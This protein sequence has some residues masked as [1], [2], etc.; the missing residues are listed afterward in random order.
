MI[1]LKEA[2]KSYYNKNILKD[3]NLSINDNDFILLVGD[4]GSG[5]STLLKLLAHTIYPN[6]KGSINC[7]VFNAYLPEKFSLPKNITVNKYIR[8]LEDYYST[9]LNNIVS[10][11]EIPYIKI[12]ELSK[13]N[14][15]KLGLITIIASNLNTVLLDEP[16][17]GMD[18]ELKK[19]F[20]EILKELKKRNKTIIISTHD[21]K[22]YKNF[23]KRI[24][25]VN[26]GQIYEENIKTI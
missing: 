5:K 10:V 13:G 24:I 11:L 9:N 22:L 26:K 6:T 23:D 25:Y 15:Q 20:I 21:V 3:I 14:L 17:E 18:K 4:N 12:S 7:D 16:C 1:I 8:F 2:N 19:K